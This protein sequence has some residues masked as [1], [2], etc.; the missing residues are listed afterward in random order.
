MLTKFNR[1]VWRRA[2]V[3]CAL[4]FSVIVTV[5]FGVILT[6]GWIALLAH[7]FKALISWAI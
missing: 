5:V 1:D 7:G 6:F 3:R 4:V 2:F